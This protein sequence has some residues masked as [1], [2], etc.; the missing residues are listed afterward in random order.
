LMGMFHSF[1]TSLGKSINVISNSSVSGFT[2]E[3]PGTI[4]FH[5]SN[6]TANQTHGFCR[7]SVPYEVLS[8]LFNVTIDGANPPYWN[9]T[10]YDNGTHQ[11]IYFEYEHSTKEVVIIPEFPFFVILPMFMLVS[12]LIALSCK[13][14]KRKVRLYN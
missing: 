3:S 11:W 7:V 6:K 8:D 10:L 13:G 14:K 12:L 5:V 1:N 4:R 2:Y 9:Y